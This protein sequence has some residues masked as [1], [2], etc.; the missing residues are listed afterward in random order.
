[1]ELG[2]AVVF[3]LSGFPE[4]LSGFTI[5]LSV[6]VDVSDFVETLVSTAELLQATQNN[7]TIA[8]KRIFFIR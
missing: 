4:L 3:T 7:T 8:T 5:A 1:L 6:T 2:F